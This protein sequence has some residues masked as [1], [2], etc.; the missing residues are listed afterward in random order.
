MAPSSSSSAVANS[1]AEQIRQEALG[2]MRRVIEHYDSRPEMPNRPRLLQTREQV[3]TLLEG[4]D[5]VL[6][7]CDGVLYRS[8]D[9]V[10][11]AAGSV[12]SLLRAGKRVFFVTNNAGA[13]R[14]QLRDKL[15]SLLGLEP[16]LL[17][18]DMM[19]GSSHSCAQYL[20]REL[21]DQKGSGKVF[22][23]GSEGLCEEL[24]QTGFEVC[25]ADPDDD[26]R[27]SMSR[28]E[29]AAYDFA[30]LHPV[31]AVVVGHDTGFSFRKLCVANVLLQWN[32][33]AL[34]VATNR[35]AFDLVG[36]DGRHIP[37]N[38]SLVRSVRIQRRGAV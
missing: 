25:R 37:G 26:G 24:R 15:T 1:V 33:G 2:E 6:F 38:G 35:D 16:D 22:V 36:A 4:V 12:R 17:T 13:N 28:E 8:P 21:L 9:P 14:R 29:L 27:A 10:P 20:R 23:I 18:E 5:T 30:P 34:L 11:G 7:D 3:A 19:V 32:P 31:D